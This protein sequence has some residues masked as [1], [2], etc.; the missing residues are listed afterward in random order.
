MEPG[1][2][3]DSNHEAEKAALSIRVLGRMFWNLYQGCLE[4]GFG[5]DQSFAIVLE[6]VYGLASRTPPQDGPDSDNF[7]ND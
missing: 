7:D 2:G 6:Y 3:I 5:K 4:A 1:E